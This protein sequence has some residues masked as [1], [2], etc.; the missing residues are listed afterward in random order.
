MTEDKELPLTKAEV[1]EGIEMMIE[2]INKLPPLA[3]Y[4]GVTQSDFLSLLLLLSSA[5]RAED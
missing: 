2:S 1:I 3:M 4:T 5:L